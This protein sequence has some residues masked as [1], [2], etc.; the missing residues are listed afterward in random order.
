MSKG[1]C[2]DPPKDRG[3]P[4]FGE[5]R[6]VPGWM[7]GWMDVINSDRSDGNTSLLETVRATES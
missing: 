6:T 5:S 4:I 7:D 1:K 3:C 2:P